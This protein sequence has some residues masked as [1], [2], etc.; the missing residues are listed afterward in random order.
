ME[1]LS[2][3]GAQNVGYIEELFQNFLSN[4]QSVDPEWRMFF[5]GIEF[6]K[7]ISGGSGSL[8]AKELKVYDLILAYRNFGHLKAK[9]DPLGLA[10]NKNVPE[11][12]FRQHGLDEKDLEASF[13][14]GAVIG[15]PKAK[16]K[17]IIASLENTYCGTLTVDFSD[18]YSEVRN[19]VLREFEKEN[20]TFTLSAEKK[21]RVL[22]QLVRTEGLEKF[23][24]TRFVGAKRFSIEGGDALMT[25]MEHLVELGASEGM[26]EL[27]F[28]MAHRGRVNML[29]NFLGKPLDLIFA[30]FDGVYN[31]NQNYVADGDVKYH[32]GY[33]TDRDVNGQSVHLSMAFNPSHLETV[34][35]VVTGMARAKQRLRK[36]NRER[37]KVIPVLAHGDAAFIGQGVV[38]ETF[39]LSQLEGYKVGGTIH[40]VSNNQVGFTTSPEY[41]RS[42]TYCTDVAKA[43]HL[44]VFH[45]N[46]DDVEACVRAAELAYKFRQHF[47]QDAVVDLVCYRRFGHNEGD[48]PAFTQPTMYSHIKAHPTLREIYS[49]KLVAQGL[50]QETEV[51][52]AM[53]GELNRIQEVL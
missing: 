35:P 34:D 10:K 32:M 30:E 39:Q 17:D 11:L 14:I 18:C 27:V 6:A 31:P 47:H 26:Q 52:A 4:P 51:N 29:A 5:E 49:K 2:Y 38:G 22:Q 19:W 42:S 41:S 15:L 23:I 45:V 3:V 12:D 37:S 43:L 9:L 28:G 48:E 1:K 44:P 8:P 33:S 13:E 50:V 25:M 21:K 40:I 36:D 24:H 53:E 16:L 20:K 7:K 46:G